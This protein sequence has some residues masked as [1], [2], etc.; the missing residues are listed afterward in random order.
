MPG[1]SRGIDTAGKLKLLTTNGLVWCYAEGINGEKL[2]LSS[3]G[4]IK[5]RSAIAAAIP[6]W[7]Y[8]VATGL[9]RQESTAKPDSYGLTCT[10]NKLVLQLLC[11][12]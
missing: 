9:W 10:I 11:N 3:P 8:D 7:R 2:Q 6:A 4:I 5:M 1:D 12:R